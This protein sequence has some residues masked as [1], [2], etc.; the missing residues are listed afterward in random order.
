MA[1]LLVKWFWQG[2]VYYF[3]LIEGKTT[4]PVQL[5]II[6]AVGLNSLH[7]SRGDWGFYGGG[8]F[9]ADKTLYNEKITCP[10][11]RQSKPALPM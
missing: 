7:H 11:D 1:V 8:S 2:K 3:A 5:K 10:R 4:K 9:D 6:N